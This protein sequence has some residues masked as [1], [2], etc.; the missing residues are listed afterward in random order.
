MT[1]KDEGNTIRDA[2]E[3]GTIGQVW[4]HQTSLGVRPNFVAS[5]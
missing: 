1:Q 4:G 5:P 3:Y 2:L